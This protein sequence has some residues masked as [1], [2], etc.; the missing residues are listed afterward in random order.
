MQ[1]VFPRV[2]PR[3]FPQLI[4][5]GISLLCSFK[6]TT[7]RVCLGSLLDIEEVGHL[8]CARDCALDSIRFQFHARCRARAKGKSRIASYLRN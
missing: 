4:S 8:R 7:Q 6:G 3:V 1:L 2:F 5:Q